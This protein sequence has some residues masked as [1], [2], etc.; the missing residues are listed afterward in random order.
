MMVET[1]VVADRVIGRHMTGRIIG[2]A[3]AGL[4]R[5][6]Q[7]QAHEFVFVVFADVAPTADGDLP[8]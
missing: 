6:A 3:C 4:A 1:A 5:P 2:L 8:L 7:R